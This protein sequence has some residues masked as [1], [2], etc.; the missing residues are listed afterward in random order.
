MAERVSDDGL[1]HI[2]GSSSYARH[3]RSMARE[4]LDRREAERLATVV[5]HDPDDGCKG[6]PYRGPLMRCNV[7]GF[8]LEREWAWG[9]APERC[10]RRTGSVIVKTP[11]VE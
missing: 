3:E 9:R 2:A 4:L 6:C 10:P 11:D 5:E 1:R 8:A 7:G